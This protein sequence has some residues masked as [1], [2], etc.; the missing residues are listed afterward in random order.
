[1][2][3]TAQ[4]VLDLARV[5][6]QYGLRLIVAFG[7]RATG[8][9]HPAS[10]LDL[11]VLPEPGTDMSLGALAD[12]TADLSRAFLGAEVDVSII[13]QADA[14]FLKKIFETAVLVHGDE[15][16]FRRYRVYAF[17]RFSEYQ[18]YLRREAQAARALIHRLRHAG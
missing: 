14:L 11:A 13:S 3:I 17:R 8:R 6:D 1:M 4:Q 7:S 9:T 10:D 5:A 18:P 16:E 2:E 15:T 12:L